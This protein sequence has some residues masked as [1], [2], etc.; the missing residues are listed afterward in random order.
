MY[1]PQGHPS[2]GLPVNPYAAPIAVPQGSYAARP[3]ID[4]YQLGDKLVLRK[5]T[6]LPDLCVVTGQPTGGQM[7]HRSLGWIPPWVAILFVL[8]PAIGLIVA[9]IVRKSGDVTF[10]WSLPARSKRTRGVLVG[11]GVLFSTFALVGLGIATELPGIALLGLVTFIVG[12][13]MAIVSGQPFQVAKIDKEFIHLKVKPAFLTAMQP[14]LAPGGHA[15]YAMG[16]APYGGMGQLPY[17]S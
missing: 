2:G 1:A 14:Y 13:V 6:V 16:Q 11:L 8:S 5:G 7:K 15:P 3:G 10:G 17:G 12:L 4:L 9:L